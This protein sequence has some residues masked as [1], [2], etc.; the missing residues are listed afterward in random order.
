MPFTCMR[1]LLFLECYC[2]G[3]LACLCNV[4]LMC[5]W[6]TQ[7]NHYGTGVLADLFSQ[8]HLR[9]VLLSVSVCC[10]AGLYC[11]V[12]VNRH[13]GSHFLGLLIYFYIYIFMLI[14]INKYFI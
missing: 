5:A 3:G 7:E 8:L 13:H 1:K 12:L 14:H 6:V 10:P 11:Q 4:L 2:L 9:F